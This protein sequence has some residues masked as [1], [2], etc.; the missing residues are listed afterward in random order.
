[1]S[2]WIYPQPSAGYESLTDHFAFYPGRIAAWLDDER[3]IAQDGDFYGGWISAELLGPF[4]RSD[5]S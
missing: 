5:A 4:R 1:M 2:E 3:V